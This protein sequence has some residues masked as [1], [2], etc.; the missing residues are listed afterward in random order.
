M[1]RKL[2]V[3]L[4]ICMQVMLCSLVLVNQANAEEDVDAALRD[5]SR[6]GENIV[7]LVINQT[8][9]PQ[10]RGFYRAFVDVWRNQSGDELGN[11]VIYERPAGRGT[12]L[13]W[14]E[15]RYRKL[16][17]AFLRTSK[18]SVLEG[19]AANAVLIVQQGIAAVRVEEILNSTDMASD[20]F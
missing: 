16:Y 9:T 4:I 1:M 10:G 5:E 3:S 14:V 12:N 17:S 2:I 8:V 18:Q 20:E 7:G 15:Y 13:L 19:M 6:Y 11:I